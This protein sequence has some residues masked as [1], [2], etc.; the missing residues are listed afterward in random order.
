[1]TI[2]LMIFV[3]GEF[4]GILLWLT[5]AKLDPRRRPGWCQRT[6]CRDR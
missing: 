1:M 2:E 3:A 5:T 4:A 6:D